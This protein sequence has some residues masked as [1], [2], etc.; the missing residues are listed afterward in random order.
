MTLSICC[1]TNAPG[2]R[3]E[4]ILEQLRPVA[5]EV[6]V[7]ADSRVGDERRREY[8]S[9]ADIVLPIDFVFAER[10]LAWLV[11]QCSSDW[12]L[13]VD[14]D[15]V[16]SPALVERLPWL[17]AQEIEQY[18]IPRR[19]LYPEPTHWLDQLP[20]WP[21]YHNRLVRRNSDLRFSGVLHTGAEPV[22]PARFLDWPLYHLECI[23]KSR[24]AREAKA[25]RAE[26]MRPGL[27]APGGGPLND[28]YYL[29]E[30]YACRPP[31]MVSA[32]DQAAIAQVTN[33]D[34]YAAIIT[35]VEHDLRFQP[36][37]RRAVHFRVH[38]LSSMQWLPRADVRLSY[39][40]VGRAGEGERT[41]FPAPVAPGGTVTVPLTVTAP[42]KLGSFELE[43]DLVHEH[44]RW[45]ERSVTVQAFVATRDAG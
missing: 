43:V 5:D 26:K 4:S 19:W 22:L 39:R 35:P 24:A 18:W 12:V 16:P 3:L 45:F 10:H 11:E 1:L 34:R 21:D 27:T 13:R 8:A 23:L 36:G 9:S 37:E 14:D 38:N 30:V 2:D 41:L 44:V 20:W 6:V 25:A 7:G 17:V 32:E 31:A 40:W 15:E 42:A 28:V 29:P 33:R